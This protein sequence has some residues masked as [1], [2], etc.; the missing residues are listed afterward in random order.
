MWG[1]GL[2]GNKAACLALA[3][4]SATSF[5]TPKQIG[6]FWWWFPGRVGEFV[7]ILWP[8]GSLQRT[9]LWGWKFLL[10]PQPPQVFTAGGFEAFFSCA[11]ILGCVVCLTPQLFLL[12]YLHVKVGP[13]SLPDATLPT[14][15]CCLSLCSLHPICS[16]PLLLP[17]W[18][19]VFSL[20][21]WLSDLCTVR[22]SYSCGYFLFLNLL[23]SV[24][25]VWEANCIYLCLCFGQ[26]ST[27]SFIY[28]AFTYL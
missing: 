6:S 11:G 21:P 5:A 14:L 24:L 28:I 1:R 2:R 18:M 7:Y 19:N 17:V 25:V 22:F 4:L 8:F 23:L 12:V 15:V 27:F 13:P 16:S 20:T 26:K 3:L 9:L 10:P